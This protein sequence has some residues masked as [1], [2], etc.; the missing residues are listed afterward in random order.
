MKAK[1]ERTELDPME[2]LMAS[3]EEGDGGALRSPSAREEATRL[4]AA[5]GLALRWGPDLMPELAKDGEDDRPK[6]ERR[7]V[8][9]I[10]TGGV[11]R[12]AFQ[13]YAEG[14]QG[15]L[16][17]SAGV[18]PEDD[19]LLLANVVIMLPDDID[20]PD[21][22]PEK[23]HDIERIFRRRRRGSPWGF[24]DA[25]SEPLIE[26][27]F[28][29]G[30]RMEFFLSGVGGAW[31]LKGEPWSE[32]EWWEVEVTF[33]AGGEKYGR[34]TYR[35]DSQ[36]AAEAERLALLRSDTSRFADVRVDYTRSA[37]AVRHHHVIRD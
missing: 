14:P 34:E 5:L 13:L 9:A 21:A 4:L 15:E 30:G 20:P 19:L 2:G 12:L 23:R 11:V 26:G 17:L 33:C 16:R 29:V 25:V 31:Y 18:P 32:W 27:T 6:R 1:D 10:D 35:V 8:E 7:S 3:R 28:R 22:A 24:T 37:S 36:E